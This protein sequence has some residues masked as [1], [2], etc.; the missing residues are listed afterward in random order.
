MRAGMAIAVVLV[1]PGIELTVSFMKAL[2]SSSEMTFWPSSSSFFRTSRSFS[3]A[4]YILWCHL[5]LV[6][7]SVWVAGA[8]A[9]RAKFL[10][11]ASEN[12]VGFAYWLWADSTEDGGA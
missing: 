6:G 11:T 4:G 7:D 12:I 2:R 1:V 3:L 5:E 9:V 8:S 10:A